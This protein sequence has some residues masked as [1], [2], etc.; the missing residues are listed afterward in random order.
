MIDYSKSSQQILDWMLDVAKL[1]GSVAF[2][3]SPE[4]D[5]WAMSQMFQEKSIVWFIANDSCSK[6]FPVFFCK[7]KKYIRF[8]LQK[9]QHFYHK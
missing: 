2:E 4:K 9:Y 5:H 8:Q 6:H 3:Y 7:Q 1:S